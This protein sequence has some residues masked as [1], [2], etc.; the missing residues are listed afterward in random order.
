VTAPPL[1]ERRTSI[2]PQQGLRS[3][4]NKLVTPDTLCRSRVSVTAPP[5]KERRTS[6]VCLAASQLDCTTRRRT[7][8]GGTKCPTIHSAL[9][10]VSP[11]DEIVRHLLE[12]GPRRRQ[13]VLRHHLEGLLL[14]LVSEC[15]LD[16]TNFA[17]QLTVRLI[18]IPFYASLVPAH[19]P[20]E[21]GAGA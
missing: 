19:R 12:V 20:P 5:L 18:S 21:N 13:H 10:A 14:W 2:P 8:P 6:V 15:S 4:H 9:S 3:P 7:S 16:V 17:S 1:T 11:E